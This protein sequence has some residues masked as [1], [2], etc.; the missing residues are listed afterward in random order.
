MEQ[1]ATRELY[2]GFYTLPA[3]KKG[4]P[5]FLLPVEDKIQIGRSLHIEG[6]RE[7]HS[8]V[9]GENIA[10]DIAAEWTERA[11]GM[12]QEC[13]PGI[14]VVRETIEENEE[15]MAEDGQKRFRAV[16]RAATEAEKRA[17]FAE[18]HQR[19]KDRQAAWLE[20]QIFKGDKI[21]AD[22]KSEIRPTPLM[23]L[24]CRYMGRNRKWLEEMRDGDIKVCPY[25]MES[26]PTAAVKCPKCHEI[27]DFEAYAA[28]EARK[29][30]AMAGIPFAEAEPELVANP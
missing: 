27:V 24:A 12:S 30:A 23:K 14:W 1:R 10:G 19:A 2:G 18:D 5:P 16:S 11:P 13:G 15:Y 4:D 6:N 29:K 9:L 20:Y 22:E 3:V 8:T 7:T 26:I 21:A 17:M 28:L 25:C